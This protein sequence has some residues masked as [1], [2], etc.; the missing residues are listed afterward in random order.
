[1]E[2]ELKARGIDTLIVTGCV[3]NCCCESTIRDA[4][5]M[6]YSIVFVADGNAARNDDDHNG[7]VADLFGIFGCD[8]ASAE[9]VIARLAADNAAKAA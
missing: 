9:E 2:A 8:V 7:A 3:S 6:N 5:Q 4:M 1:M